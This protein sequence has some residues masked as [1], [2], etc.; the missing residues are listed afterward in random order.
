MKKKV[1]FDRRAQKEIK[2]LSTAVQAK[3]TVLI[4]VLERDGVLIEPYGKKV[5]EHLFEMRVKVQGQWRL[6]YAYVLI[7]QVVILTVFQKKTQK[8]PLQELEKAKQ[9]LKEYQI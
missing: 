3:I 5:D 8:T 9:R 6:L 1:F 4:D 2:K 7:D